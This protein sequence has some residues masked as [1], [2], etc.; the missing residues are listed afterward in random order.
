MSVKIRVSYTE[1]DELIEILGA[2]SN[3]ESLKSYKIRSQ[4]GRYKLAYININAETKEKDC[5]FDT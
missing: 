5:K 4:K 2:L 1:D 3:V